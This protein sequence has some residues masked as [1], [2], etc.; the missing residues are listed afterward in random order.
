MT[1]VGERKEAERDARQPATS[2]TTVDRTVRERS[3][4][5]KAQLLTGDNLKSETATPAEVLTGACPNCGWT[6][7]IYPQMARYRRPDGDVVE[8][9]ADPASRA[10]Y[11]GKG[12]TLLDANVESER[13]R[14]INSAVIEEFPRHDP[15]EPLRHTP[16]DPPS[17]S[18]VKQVAAIAPERVHPEHDLQ[19]FAVQAEKQEQAEAKQ[20]EKD[21]AQ[22]RREADTATA[23]TKSP[24][25]PTADTDRTGTRTD[26]AKVEQ[27][28]EDARK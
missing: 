1:T 5:S 12:F 19:K 8:L 24:A 17:P 4:E 22:A 13:A 11:T 20:Q 7:P 26:A 2:Q 10:M 25:S 9:R 15:R 21:A 23:Q 27:R 28:K 16:D 18:L 3:Q 14:R 6:P